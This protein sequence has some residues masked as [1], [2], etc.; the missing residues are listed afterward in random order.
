MSMKKL[1][2][3]AI[4]GRANVGKSSLFNRF[5]EKRQAI[6]ADEPGTT[7]DAVYGKVHLPRQ[8]FWLVDTAGLK[9]AED[10]FELS[11]QDQI[12][13]AAE[14]ADILLVVIEHGVG[15][16][17]ED[18]RV[19][20]MAL[21]SQK[22]VYLVVNKAD[23]AKESDIEPFRRLGIK[24]IFLTS[25]V[26]NR[27]IEELADYIAGG[28]PKVKD[29]ADPNTLRISFIGRPNVGKSSLFNT[30]L[31]KQKAVVADVAGTTRDVNRQE[32]RYHGTSVELLDTAG[33]RRSGKIERGIEH[34]SVLRALAAIEE[35]DIC[36]MVMDATELNTKLDQRIAGL[37]REAG[38]GVII[39][40]S[41]WD[42]VDKDAY[43]RDQMA[44][45]IAREFPFI[46]WAP[47]IFTSSETGQN[48]SKLFDLA[49]EIIEAR[50]QQIQTKDLNRWLKEV[51]MPCAAAQGPEFRSRPYRRRHPSQEDHRR[52]QAC[53]Q[54]LCR[55]QQRV[56]RHRHKNN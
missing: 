22:P 32:T 44:A 48:V 27:G 52:R 45:E 36:C 54:D 4:V 1:P 3:V 31:A 24:E 50:S 25:A 41:K 2:I 20:K 17:D 9:S 39:V 6:I 35:S 49:F 18:R 16:T 8:S 33:I 10:E 56:Q 12:Q 13:E 37:I 11:I 28:L 23:D 26:H 30:L 51:T 7:R 5:V 15:I 19:A 21:K 29:K 43:T 38:R 40:V 53:Q 14:A 47:L 34:F 42:L 55:G 46:S